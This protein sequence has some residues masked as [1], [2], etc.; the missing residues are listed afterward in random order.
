MKFFYKIDTGG[1]VRLGSGMVEPKGFSPYTK[2]K[3]PKVLL[4]ILNKQKFEMGKSE[5]IKEIN[6]ACAAAITG[7]F[8]SLGLGTQR[9]YKSEQIDQLNLIGLVTG[10]V[11]DYLK[12]ATPGATLVWTY[13]M[14][15]T[16]QLKKVLNDGKKY[17]QG[18]LRKAGTLKSAVSQA[19]TQA[20]LDVIVW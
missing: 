7:G 13:E 20:D 4:D 16:A 9:R 8:D 17:K 10:G 2:G 11:S 15:T 1:V 18:L 14:H 19:T 6:A 12:C 5:K 3:E